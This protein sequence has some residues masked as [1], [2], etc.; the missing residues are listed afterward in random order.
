MYEARTPLALGVS[1]RPTHVNVHTCMTLVRHVLD[2]LK[3]VSQFYFIFVSTLLRSVSDTC[4]TLIPHMS[5][6][7]NKCPILFLLCFDTPM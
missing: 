4:M 1:L 5:N 3:P 7:S 6:N 2:Y